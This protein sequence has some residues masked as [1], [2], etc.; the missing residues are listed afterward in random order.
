MK[1]L[2]FKANPPPIY[3]RVGDNRNA[4]QESQAVKWKKLHVFRMT[5]SYIDEGWVLTARQ[6][7]WMLFRTVRRAARMGN[8]TTM[9]NETLRWGARYGDDFRV[10][11]FLRLYGGADSQSILDRFYGTLS[12]P[13]AEINYLLFTELKKAR[14]CYVARHRLKRR[15]QRVLPALNP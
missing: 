10:D 15:E 11:L 5:E 12:D 1:D 7:E 6:S 9:L 2:L 14:K 3:K 13:S 4:A 8:G